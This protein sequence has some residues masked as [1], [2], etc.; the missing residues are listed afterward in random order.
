MNT[1]A[2]R[3]QAHVPYL[4]ALQSALARILSEDW[5]SVHPDGKYASEGWKAAAF[6]EKN[7][8]KTERYSRFA[9]I[10]H[11]LQNNFRCEIKMA[12]FYSMEPGAWIKPHRDLS[13]TMELGRIRF[14]IPVVTHDH[15]DFRVSKKRV[16][17]R[18]GELW[19]LNTSYRHEVVNHS[20][21]T[22]V[23]FV[24]EAQLNEWCWS[25]LPAKTMTWYV[26]GAFFF[27]HAAYKVVA[28]IFSSPGGLKL[29]VDK[30]RR[31][32]FSR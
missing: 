31:Y 28:N 1:G 27:A 17:M 2:Y 11:I 30:I 9:E 3:I 15:V 22:R 21:V 8:V 5:Q 24:V 12:V 25:L 13:G 16:V 19:A 32:S 26:H 14:H 29:L 23:H 6:V 18:P 4:P 10:A 20:S 7:G